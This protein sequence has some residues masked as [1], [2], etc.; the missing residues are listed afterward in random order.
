MVAYLKRM[1]AE[2]TNFKYGCID[3]TEVEDP[4]K[5]ESLIK[6]YNPEPNSK[7]EN[8]ARFIAQN[9]VELER[10]VADS[11]WI[12]GLLEGFEHKKFHRSMISRVLKILPSFLPVR[13]EIHGGKSR[14][15]LPKS[16][17][18]SSVSSGPVRL[19]GG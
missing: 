4:E 2:L 1:T 18:D 9:L 6:A 12:R 3:S 15:V 16:F 8:R 10:P 13:V 5:P 7:S 19:G 14:A 11:T 17:F